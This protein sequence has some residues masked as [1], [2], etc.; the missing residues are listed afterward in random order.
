[1]GFVPWSHIHLRDGVVSG[2]WSEETKEAWSAVVAL[3]GNLDSDEWT[4]AEAELYAK[5]FVIALVF[6]LSDL[7]ELLWVP[8]FMA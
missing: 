6:T 2:V 4:D 5:V 8:V 7:A 1:M 3:N